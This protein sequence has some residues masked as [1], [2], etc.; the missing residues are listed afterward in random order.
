MDFI[1]KSPSSK[2]KSKSK[3]PS[4]SSKSKSSKSKS[5]SIYTKAV[6]SINTDLVVGD[7]TNKGTCIQYAIINKKL[8]KL[9]IDQFNTKQNFKN[10]VV[11][12]FPGE[13]DTKMSVYNYIGFAT[14]EGKYKVL[15]RTYKKWLE[16]TFFPNTTFKS[17]STDVT[18]RTQSYDKNKDTY[19]V[20][21]AY[22]REFAKKTIF[23]TKKTE[24]THLILYYPILNNC[25]EDCG[26]KI[27]YMNKNNEI[28]EVILPADNNIVYCIRDCCFVH[29]TPLSQPEVHGMDIDRVLVRSYVT[30]EGSEF[31]ES[32]CPTLLT[33]GENQKKRNYKSRKYRILQNRT[34]KQKRFTLKQKSKVGRTSINTRI[35]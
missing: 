28:K 29:M 18:L 24:N 27:K 22:H 25:K 14:F 4:P 2:S 21:S 1:S 16:T 26:T 15:Y 19:E 20:E 3:S 5:S 31:E 12:G 32:L 23:H 7:E 11:P 33:G 6:D 10:I 17:F 9:F 30:P 8:K 35:D 34:K 13:P